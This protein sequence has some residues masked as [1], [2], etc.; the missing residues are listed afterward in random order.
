[1]RSERADLTQMNSGAA[2]HAPISPVEPFCWSLIIYLFSRESFVEEPHLSKVSA[3]S[4]AA[5]GECFDVTF[6][7]AVAELPE[8]AAQVY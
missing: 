4:D 5:S 3:F 7:D 8:R 2:R 1:M 6:A